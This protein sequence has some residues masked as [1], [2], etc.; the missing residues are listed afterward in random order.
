MALGKPRKIKRV[1]HTITNVLKMANTK[2]L[3]ETVSIIRFSFNRI[4]TRI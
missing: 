2:V 3:S 4:F 1:K